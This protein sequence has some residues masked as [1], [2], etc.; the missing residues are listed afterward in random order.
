MRIRLA[1][2]AACLLLAGCAP[3]VSAPPPPSG[4]SIPSPPATSVLTPGES[5]TAAGLRD[6]Q[7]LLPA[8]FG[9]VEAH[10]FPVGQDMLARLAAELGVEDDDV[11]V[12]FASDHG[13]AFIQM[14]AMRV[15]GSTADQVADALTR[16]AY[17]A[18]AQPRVSSLRLADRDLAVIRDE[19]L[20]TQRGTF[21]VLSL[22]EQ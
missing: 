21:Y 2:T 18:E 1:A 16:T 4:T 7:D 3:A 12:A 10:T 22:P 5:S 6:L 20:A 19:A 13:P 8:D 17:P 11:Q 14:F 9:G 15:V